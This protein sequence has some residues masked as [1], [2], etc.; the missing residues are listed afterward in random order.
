MQRDRSFTSDLSSKVY[1]LLLVFFLTAAL[2]RFIII[3]YIIIIL[4]CGQTFY[5]NKHSDI[6]KNN[7][8]FQYY[9]DGLVE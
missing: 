3:L 6:S 9:S 1:T 2:Y 8:G 7:I 5:Q 4:F